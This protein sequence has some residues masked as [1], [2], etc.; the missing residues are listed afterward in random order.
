MRLDGALLAPDGLEA[1]LDALLGGVY[2]RALAVQLAFALPRLA[3]GVFTVF[4]GLRGLAPEALRRA[5]VAA[6]LAHR[7]RGA[8][9]VP[10]HLRRR[11]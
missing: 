10:A 4:L 5:G 9:V 2:A 11:R 8:V 3:L 1:L 7:R 6:L